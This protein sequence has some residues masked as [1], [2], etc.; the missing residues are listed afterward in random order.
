MR[1]EQVPADSHFFDDLGADSLVMAKFCARVRKRGD[2]PPVSMKDIYRHPRSRA[3]RRRSRTAAPPAQAAPRPAGASDPA[4]R[5]RCWRRRPA[6]GSTSC[7]GLFS[8]CSSSAMPGWPRWPALGL[9]WISAGSG[10][11][12][13][14][15]RAVL[16]GGAA[17][18]VL[19]TPADPGQVGADRPVETPADPHLEPGVCPVLDRQDAGPVNPLAPGVGSPLY[20]LY[21]RALGA[22][23]G[24]GTVIFSKHVPVCTDLL[25]IGA[26]T[27]IR[28]DAFF[29][30]L[31]GA[32]GLD[33]DRPGQRS[34]G[35]RSSARR[36]CSTSTPSM[37]D[38]AQ[39]GH[40]SALHSGQAIPGG[41]RWHGSPA[42]RTEV[43]Y[44]R[45]ARRAA[46]RC[47]GSGSAPSP[48]S[49]CSCCTCRWPKGGCTCC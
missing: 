6:R 5:R 40:A 26:G 36:A 9:R 20:A 19:C 25:T 48:C 7:A 3:W 37:G 44:L 46:A 47:A 18:L 4:G 17:F 21:L 41:Q 33:P 27:V 29:Q 42:Q 8:S 43:N 10:L 39:L 38:G 11:A 45:V 34:A 30:L 15:L 24:P 35:T 13:I 49:A 31:P 1:A 23:V 28:K 14:Y 16:F 2:L 12:G 22:K 32:G